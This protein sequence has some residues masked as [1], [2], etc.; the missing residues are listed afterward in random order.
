MSLGNGNYEKKDKKYYPEVYSGLSFYNESS[1]LN[2]R[3]CL[4]GILEMKIVPKTPAGGF[5]NENAIA[6]YISPNKAIMLIQAIDMLRS[7][8]ANEGKIPNFGVCNNRKTGN[9]EFGA[10]KTNGELQLYVTIYKYSQNGNISDS[11]TFAFESKDDFIIKDFSPNDLSYDKI[12]VNDVPLT[13]ISILLK[14]YVKGVSGGGAYGVDYNVGQ[15]RYNVG[16]L[17]KMLIGESKPSGGYNNQGNSIF[18]N[19]N[20]DSQNNEF[21]EMDF[22][23]LDF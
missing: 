8:L 15:Y 19:G 10:V 23:E 5:D 14:E 6:I 13:E 21:E 4:K 22:D 12:P 7:Q 1:A 11:C 20:K 17:K 18:N 16:S 3:F 2:F 9:V